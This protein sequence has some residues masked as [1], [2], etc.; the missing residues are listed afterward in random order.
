MLVA[1]AELIFVGLQA[2]VESILFESDGDGDG[3]LGQLT[4]GS[5][6]GR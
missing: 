4:N 6:D 2:L 1:Y 3:G 5:L